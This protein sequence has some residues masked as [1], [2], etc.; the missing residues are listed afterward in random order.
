LAAAKLET[1]ARDHQ[2]KKATTSKRAGPL[3]EAARAEN[4]YADSPRLARRSISPEVN[5]T[6][7]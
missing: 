2:M 3:S 5:I 6:K 4:A 1:V 7:L